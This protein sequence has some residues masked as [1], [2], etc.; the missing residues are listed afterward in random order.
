MT[1]LFPPFSALVAAAVI[2]GAVPAASRAQEPKQELY[3]E[4]YVNGVAQQLL[5]D[6]ELNGDRLFTTLDELAAAG[7]LVD[8]LAAD[9]NG[10]VAIDA[11]PQ[12]RYRYSELEQRIDLELPPSRLAPDLLGYNAP[13]TT[14]PHSDK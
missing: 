14:P 13:S 4:L 12:A 8:D 2:G 11:I 5:L 10:L 3:L 7:I 6:F 9:A 1:R